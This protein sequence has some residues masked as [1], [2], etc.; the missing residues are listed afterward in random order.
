MWI[1]KKLQC[2]CRVFKNLIKMVL[3]K[4]A[5][6]LKI[7]TFT[8]SFGLIKIFLPDMRSLGSVL[9]FHCTTSLNNLSLIVKLT[10]EP[11]IY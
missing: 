5:A 9:S 10:A 1:K 6:A 11:F 8:C 3:K 4:T 7:Q 2:D